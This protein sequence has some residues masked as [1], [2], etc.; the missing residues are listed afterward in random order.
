MFAFEQISFELNPL[1]QS[2]GRFNQ[3]IDIDRK[4]AYNNT[5]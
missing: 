1:S 5:T 2:Y 3:N 4:F